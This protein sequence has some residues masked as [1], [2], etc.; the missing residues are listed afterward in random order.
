MTLA[1][2]KIAHSEVLMLNISTAQARQFIMTPERIL[3]YY[4]GA[5]GCGTLEEGKKIFCHNDGVISLLE[6]MSGGGENPV[7]IKVTS[8]GLMEAPITEEKIAANAFFVM[9]E[10]WL[11]DEDGAGTRLTKTWRDISCSQPDLPSM[12]AVVKESAIEEGASLVAGWNA[13]AQAG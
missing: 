13:A 12:D 5:T 7:V 6:R 1:E 3:D 8:A 11:L 4:P 9:F 10:D 2:A